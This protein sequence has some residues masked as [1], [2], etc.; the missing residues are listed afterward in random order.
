MGFGQIY[1]VSWWGDTNAPSGWGAIYPF[2]ADGGILSVDTTLI[3]ADATN[4]TAD[5][6]T[7]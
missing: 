4:F 2:N 7:F 6:T 1:T 3:T 5:Q